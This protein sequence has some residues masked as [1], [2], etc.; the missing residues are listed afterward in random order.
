MTPRP[1]REWFPRF[2]RKLLAGDEDVRELLERD[3]FP[4]D[5]PTHVRVRRYRYEYTTPAERR[6]TGKWWR[7]EFV[8]RYYGPVSSR[9]M[10]RGD[11]RH[12]IGVR[13]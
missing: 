1:R 12:G 11:P 8:N 4:A 7:R 3:P 10:R 5:P 13:Q 6:E 9:D 2:V